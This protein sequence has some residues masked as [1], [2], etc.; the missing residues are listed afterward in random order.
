MA[1][2]QDYIF[3]GQSYLGWP[4][5]FEM[6]KPAPA[7]ANR[8]FETLE[9]AQGFLSDATACVGIIL[10]VV[11]DGANNG[12]Y[13]VEFDSS[14][15]LKLTK[16]ATGSISA[17][18]E[19]VWAKYNESTEEWEE[20]EGS[21][22]P[23]PSLGYQ[24]YLKITIGE[25]AAYVLLSELVDLRE[26]YKKDETDAA[27]AKAV[28]D[29]AEIARAAEEV[30]TAAIETE[31]TEREAADASLQS[32]IDAEIARATAAEETLQD[33][34]DAE[35]ARAK[36]EEAKKVD[37]K[38]VTG[39]NIAEVFNEYD[40]GGAKFTHED[41][42]ES[43]VGVN[44]GGATGLAAQ[45]YVDE[46]DPE[47]GYVGTR[48]NVYKNGAY[49]YD[50][51]TTRS[52]KADETYTGH[53]PEREI[54]TKADIAAIEVPE[55]S[56]SKDTTSGD[57][58]AVYHL[59]KGGANVGEAINI[60]KD[61]VV[62]K[63][64]VVD[65]DGESSTITVDGE[66]VTVKGEHTEGKYVVMLMQNDDES[67]V[68]LDVKDLVDV[69][70]AGEGIVISDS[71]IISIDS[72]VV[73]TV[74]YVDSKDE[75]LSNAITTE[76]TRAKAAEEAN[77]TAIAKEIERAKAAEEAIAADVS[78]LEETVDTIDDDVDAIKD[79]IEA[80]DTSI[81]TLEID[82][83]EEAARAK[84]AEETL[85][86]KIDEVVEATE[87]TIN[88]IYSEIG[89]LDASVSIIEERLETAEDKLGD[90][91]E[92]AQ[93][94]V[95]ET[96]KV[97]GTALEV[98]EKTV[99]IKVPQIVR[100]DASAVI[101]GEAK[102]IDNT[103]VLDEA[104]DAL[105]NDDIVVLVA[106]KRE[107][108]VT[109]YYGQ[110]ADAQFRAISLISTDIADPSVETADVEQV[111]YYATIWTAGD[112]KT[113]TTYDHLSK[114][115]IRALGSKVEIGANMQAIATKSETT[116]NDGNKVYTIELNEAVATGDASVVTETDNETV[117]TKGYVDYR[118][119]WET[120]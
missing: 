101:D 94:N 10:R 119:A 57:Y 59:T 17:T 114:A 99:D 51:K 4:H 5:S 3:D 47:L 32:D 44:N 75:E 41:G 14:D 82:V 61:V 109:K 18:G 74:N 56:I 69:Y 77:A 34:I 117:A 13:L 85:D 38:I 29:E 35:E 112:G 87:K 71:N 27:I 108:T 102:V 25:S 103:T 104:F 111:L 23:D 120:L 90:I 110:S 28:A 48:V 118:M 89:D 95:I 98:S 62:R 84:G 68:W 76:E 40:G 96:V 53:N 63:A 86:K 12:A 78:T 64:G 6:N 79:Q 72:S 113:H 37:K 1:E 20:W 26:Y 8:V 54:A 50:E 91:E 11:K 105:Y 66:T 7:I 43:F 97:N 33:A 46:S 116:D 80:I 100:I 9:A 45:I 39:D 60:P 55:Y 52:M 107:Y 42:T 65:Y 36:S 16:I 31:A 115:E 49:Y 70:T 81:Q 73:A 93:V 24:H 58:A 106:G 19:T 15:A 22:D 30:L 92:G 83:A 88:D 21:E 67:Q 2:R